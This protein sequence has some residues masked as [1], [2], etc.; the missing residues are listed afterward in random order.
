[1]RPCLRLILVSDKVLAVFENDLLRFVSAE[2]P[3]ERRLVLNEKR[4]IM[5]C[6]TV[7]NPLTLTP[8]LFTNTSIQINWCH[9]VIFFNELLPVWWSIF[10]LILDCCLELVQSSPGL[11]VNESG[12]NV[13][14]SVYRTVMSHICLVYLLDITMYNLPGYYFKRFQKNHTVHSGA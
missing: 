2:E 4:H 10:F 5:L 14:A 13:L 12:L 3:I 11:A 6:L 7:Q 8:P 1:M 9:L